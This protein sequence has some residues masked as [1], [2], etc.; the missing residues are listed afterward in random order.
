MDGQSLCTTADY[1][2]DETGLEQGAESKVI[3]VDSANCQS[4]PMFVIYVLA[5]LD[6]VRPRA[7][8][9]ICLFRAN[10]KT[11]FAVL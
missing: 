5:I 2:K 8:F 10:L 9:L 7:E 4:N 3:S 6:L 1:P 11:S